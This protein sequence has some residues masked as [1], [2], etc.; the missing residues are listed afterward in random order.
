MIVT[1]NDIIETKQSQTDEANLDMITAIYPDNEK[2][3]CKKRFVQRIVSDEGEDIDHKFNL[4]DI[5]V[6]LE[7]K[8]NNGQNC[9]K[10]FIESGQFERNYQ[11]EVDE[12]Y[13]RRNIIVFA[14]HKSN[15][16]YIFTKELFIQGIYIKE[17]K[18]DDCGKWINSFNGLSV[19][20]FI[21]IVKR[22]IFSDNML[23]DVNQFTYFYGQKLSNGKEGIR[24]HKIF[25]L[26]TDNE[27]K[28][29]YKSI[30][31]EF[32]TLDQLNWNLKNNSKNI[33]PMNFDTLYFDT[34]KLCY[35]CKHAKNN[36]KETFQ[37]YV[38]FGDFVY[39][40]K[41]SF[42]AS[43]FIDKEKLKAKIIRTMRITK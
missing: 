23:L 27:G 21:N 6:Y 37:I 41:E 43:D 11:Y 2:I 31:N 33:E 19:S 32:M 26:D 20:Q 8:Y 17:Y 29:I 36:A 34:N 5:H 9:L 40:L 7:A 16:P 35:N 13:C 1:I 18:M 25:Y 4:A 15:K 24:P 30:A 22:G 3:Y 42:Y 39:K 10:K 14:L 38:N 12:N 28:P